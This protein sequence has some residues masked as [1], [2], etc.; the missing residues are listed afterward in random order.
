MPGNP[1]LKATLNTCTA[2]LHLR[3]EVLYGYFRFIA[4]GR[5]TFPVHWAHLLLQSWCVKAQHMLTRCSAR[6]DTWSCSSV[7]QILR[8]NGICSNWNFRCWQASMIC[9]TYSLLCH[10]N[11]LEIQENKK[12]GKKERNEGN[13]EA[14]LIYQISCS[15]CGTKTIPVQWSTLI[16][17]LI[18]VPSQFS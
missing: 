5:P 16:S 2:I 1:G 6:A 12:E 17:R 7:W 8:K 3:W 18:G 4:R 15:R 14:E 9:T 11:Y 10:E 13:C